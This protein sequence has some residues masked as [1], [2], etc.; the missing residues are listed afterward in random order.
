MTFTNEYPKKEITIITN[1]KIGSLTSDNNAE[2]HFRDFKGYLD[3]VQHI[4][5]T[6][7]RN[8]W[9]EIK[10]ANIKETYKDSFGRK[11]EVKVLS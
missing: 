1:V 11:M 5:L 8:V 4:V 7:S 6:G 9:H 3:T 2:I 10:M